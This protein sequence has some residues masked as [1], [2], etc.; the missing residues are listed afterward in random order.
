MYSNSMRFTVVS[1]CS[2]SAAQNMAM[3]LI[4]AQIREALAD[5][6]SGP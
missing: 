1:A 5:A 2:G 6:L 4:D 3:K